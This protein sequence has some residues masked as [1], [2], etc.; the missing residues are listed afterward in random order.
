MR[1]CT[2]LQDGWYFKKGGSIP[3]PFRK[4]DPQW[5][6]VTLPHDWAIEG[7]FDGWYEPCYPLDRE[8]KS[9]VFAPGNASGAL[10]YTGTGYYVHTFTLPETEKGRSFLL[11]FDGVMSHST[12]LVN[13]QIVGGRVYGYSSFA[14]DITNAVK[15]GENHPNTI[16]VKVENPS[17]L[18]R[19]YPGAGI[20]REVRLL[21]L[22][23]R[24]FRYNGVHLKTEKL[25]CRRKSAVLHVTAEGF[26]AE[27]LFLKV[28]RNGKLIAQGGAELPLEKID[29]W[30]PEDPALYK[31][32]VKAG[33]DEVTFSYGFRE[34]T[35]DPDKGMTLNGSPYR[36]R[37][38]CMHHDLGVFGAA[39]H[40]E[41]MAW[42]LKK[43]KALGCNALRMAHNPPDPQLLDLCDE[44]GFLV[45]DEAFD[46]W[47]I[48]KSAGDYHN[49]FD[50]C[51]EQDLRDMIRRDRNHP[52]I[53]LWSIGN[54]IPDEILEQ[55][56]EIAKELVGICH[57][58]DP[59]RP[60]TAAI[61][62]QT[63]EDKAELHAFAETLDVLGFN[64][65]PDLYALM[66]QRFP[67]K[68]IYG[69]ETSAMV[70]SRGNT[71]SRKK[72]RIS[73]ARKGITLLTAQNLPHGAMMRRSCSRRWRRTP[74]SWGNLPGVPLIIWE[75]PFPT[76]FPT[77]VPVLLY[78]IWLDCP[79]TERIST[80]PNGNRGKC[81]RY[82]ICCLTGIGQRA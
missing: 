67:H 78:T 65:R 50:S 38:L 26:S 46:V 73:I 75:N 28:C 40:K 29:L 45:M 44:M 37:G 42:R 12:I 43:V 34:V 35:F 81:L 24:S 19:W 64:Y 49:E 71:F 1:K 21:S 61:N 56:A 69:S 74:G 51:H 5:Q 3:T 30:S 53:V 33:E 4:D 27:E 18:A 36:F 25:D 54:E 80:K 31:V 17:Y 41:V 70:S 79:R 55:G 48:R 68:P 10:P 76:H 14:C 47:K 22:P 20:Y 63:E 39:F 6:E 58:E 23:P 52:C 16:V 11:E 60:V 9:I 77:E 2:I 57:E 7:P 82:C 13:D 59:S 15:F 62:H 8:T 66:H 32:T 72:M